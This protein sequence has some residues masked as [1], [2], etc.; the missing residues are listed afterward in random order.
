MANI[1]VREAREGDVQVVAD[2]VARLKMLNEE[3]DP[4]FKAVENIEEVAEEYV[5]KAIEDPNTLV[6]VAVDGDTETVAG[7]IILKIEDRI[8]YEPRKKALITD[9]YVRAKY[10]RRRLGTLLLEQA[11]EHAKEKGAGLITAVYPAGNIIAGE[12]Y[13]KAGFKDLLVEKYKPLY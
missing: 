2:M 9:F 13:S 4:H 11:I 12:F 7:V 10:R 6:I 1:Y 3:L 5:R 8:F